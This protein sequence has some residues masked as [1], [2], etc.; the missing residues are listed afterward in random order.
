MTARPAP[1]TDFTQRF[2]FDLAP[3]RGRILRLGETWAT[4]RSRRAYRSTA[5][6]LLADLAV[7]SGLLAQ[8]LKFDGSVII[9]IRGRPAENV[10]SLGTAMAECRSQ[11][12][13]RGIVR[14]DVGQTPLDRRDL[15][16]LFGRGELAIT[17]RPDV[18]ETYQG[19]VALGS[20][21]LAAHLERYFE[22]SE[23]LPTRLWLASDTR[24]A[25]GLML[26]RLPGAVMD[27]AAEDHW[28]RLVLL[29][30]T[31]TERELLGLGTETLLRR[32]FNQ[33]RV[34]L[35]P[36]AALHFGCSCTR[37]RSSNAVRLLGLEAV[38][39]ILAEDGRL[40]VTCE[41]CGATYGYDSVDAAYLFSAPAEPAPGPI[42]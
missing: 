15:S 33:D 29:A 34:R 1:A 36:P 30:G 41:F 25:T 12:Q 42:H 9:Q 19:I 17:L 37:E 38:N 3:V 18:G 4:L 7:A 40:D 28:Q 22:T 16:A 5:E 13:I 26:Q 32:L 23:Q 10:P 27:D 2:S 20:G 21:G 8:D 31:L 14:G 39:E 6:T 24:C 11:A 35:M